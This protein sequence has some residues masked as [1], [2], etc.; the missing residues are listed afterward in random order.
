MITDESIEIVREGD[1][2]TR[3]RLALER[4]TKF[5]FAPRCEGCNWRLVSEPISSKEELLWCRWCVKRLMAL[6]RPLE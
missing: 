1:R 4:L 6:G 2:A 3:E 5:I